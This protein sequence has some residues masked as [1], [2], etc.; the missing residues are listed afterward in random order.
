M[1]RSL[2]NTA[3]RARNDHGVRFVRSRVHTVEPGGQNDLVL[4]YATE[5][6]Q[7]GQRDL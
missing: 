2:I 3:L 4:R 6:G 7:W 1:A 5:E